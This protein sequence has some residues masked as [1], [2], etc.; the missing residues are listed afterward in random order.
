[1]PSTILTTIAESR[2]QSV[3][4]SLEQKKKNNRFYQLLSHRTTPAI[5]GE[6]KFR[7]PSAGEIVNIAPYDRRKFIESKVNAYEK[8]GIH[9]ISIVTESHFFNGDTAFVTD[10]K[11][12]TS[13]PVLMKDFIVHPLQII[14]A[15]ALQPDALLLIAKLLSPAELFH[16]VELCFACGIE[17]VVEINT[18]TELANALTTDARCIAVN[19]RDLTTFTV[20][21]EQAVSLLQ[22][23]PHDRLRLAFS[24]V[25]THDDYQSYVQSQ[26][27]AILI[28]TTLMKSENVEKTLKEIVHN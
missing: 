28:G 15:H 9:A 4:S 27:Q 13:L 21:I 24:G 3:T 19:A 17:P 1:M 22:S 6:I 25:Q 18:Q 8:A 11:N 20:D 7:S 5:I 14:E 16:F 12:I 26:A 23:I 10:V 2:I